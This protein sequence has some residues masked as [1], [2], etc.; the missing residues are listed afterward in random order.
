MSVSTARFAPG[1]TVQISDR[2]PGVHHRV[3]AYAKGQR[4]IVERVCGRHGQPE[5][6]IRGDGGE[7]RTLYR[8]TLNQSELWHDYAGPAHDTLDIEIFEHWLEDAS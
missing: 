4:G 3:P 6:F 8:V 1:Q 7:P 5:K 2:Q